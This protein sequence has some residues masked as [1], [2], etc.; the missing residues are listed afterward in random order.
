MGNNFKSKTTN[1]DLVNEL[2]SRNKERYSFII[3]KAKNY[4]YHCF[5][6][7]YAFPKTNLVSDLSTFNLELKD[8]INDVVNG[9]YDESM[10]S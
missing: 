7:D 4:D 5:K 9:V 6:S 3:E 1:V 2:E 8:I 10:F